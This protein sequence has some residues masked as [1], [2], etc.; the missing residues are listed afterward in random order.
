MKFTRNI[1]ISILIVA[2]LIIAAIISYATRQIVVNN[3]NAN[4]AVY[5]EARW[6]AFYSNTKA[7][8]NLA[9]SGLKYQSDNIS[10][11][12]NNNLDREKLLKTIRTNEFYPEFDKM[13]RN[14]LENNIFTDNDQ[15]DPNRNN[16][17]VLAN[18]HMIANYG[19]AN[20]YSIKVDEDGEKKFYIRNNLS[21]IIKDKFYNP[22][23]SSEALEKVL[24]QSDD[25]IVWQSREGNSEDPKYTHIGLEQLKEIFFKHGV[26]GFSSY[27]ILIPSYITERGDIFGEYVTG[28]EPSEDKLIIVQKLN[29][30]DYFSNYNYVDRDILTLDGL[31]R[32]EEEYHNTTSYIFIFQILL[33]TCIGVFIYGVCVSINDIYNDDDEEELEKD[34]VEKPTKA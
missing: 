33:Y 18:G 11:E 30:R 6:N 25:I 15:M 29:L 31:K 1:R 8:I 16:I 12:I 26:D 4:I 14:N 20:I 22:E 21:D 2:L 34:I 27:E 17:F 23:L 10:Y 13:L 32:L 28:N 5:K 7:A 3:Y 9:E 19:Y 24:M